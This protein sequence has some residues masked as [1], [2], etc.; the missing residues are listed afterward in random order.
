MVVVQR[1][2]LIF[3]LALSVILLEAPTHKHIQSCTDTWSS[4]TWMQ[5]ST[6]RGKQVVIKNTENAYQL[7]HVLGCIYYTCTY[8]VSCRICGFTRRCGQIN[9]FQHLIDGLQGF[10]WFYLNYAKTERETVIYIKC[11]CDDVIHILI[12][13]IRRYKQ[14]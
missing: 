4:D 11:I 5:T 7:C 3:L 1:G 6:Y 2:R 14:K 9:V 13:C 10:L 8:T 12:Y